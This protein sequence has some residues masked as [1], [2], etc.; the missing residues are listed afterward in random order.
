MLHLLNKAH[1]DQGGQIFFVKLQGGNGNLV[2]SWLKC[3]NS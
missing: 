3:E 1:E 2:T